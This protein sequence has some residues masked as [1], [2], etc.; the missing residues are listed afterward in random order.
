MVSAALFGSLVYGQDVVRVPFS[1]PARQRVVKLTMISGSIHVKGY[2]GNEVVIET[3]GAA[4]RR[5]EMDGL[6]RIDM[7]PGYT[8]EEQ[9][10]VVT[11]K[12]SMNAPGSIDIQVPA[13][14]SL[15]LSTVNGGEVS[16][17]GVEGELDVKNTNGSVKMSHVA[18][19]VVANALNGNVIAV[20]DRVT[21]GRPMSFSSLNGTV[22]V[23]LPADTK[24]TLKMR[25]DNGDVYSDFDITLGSAG[26]VTTGK[27][28]GGRYRVQVDKT[29]A[30][31]INGGGPEIR[32]TT[33]N[34]R[35]MLRKAK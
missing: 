8:A 9:D 6:R 31:T 20:L 19:V 21:P 13:R 28:P 10:N 11:I 27:A 24:A 35:V 23:T 33:M 5:H 7:T 17:D 22:D 2:N 29:I 34:G 4:N 25:S 14:T 26:Q 16:V 12:P 32:L 1:D 18:G 30:G 15:Q 3:K